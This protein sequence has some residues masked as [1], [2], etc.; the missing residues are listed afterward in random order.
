MNK[1]RIDSVVAI[2][3]AGDGGGKHR[4][5]ML[6]GVRGGY[7]LLWHRSANA[8][9][10]GNMAFVK[11]VMASAKTTDAEVG[12]TVVLESGG[13]IFY[14]I[15]IP[16]VEDGQ[17]EAIVEMQ[18]ETMLPV[19]RDEIQ[20]ASRTDRSSGGRRKVTAAI[21]RNEK[22]K[23]VVPIAKR[24]QASMVI[25]DCEGVVRAWKELFGG[26]DGK[27]VLVNIGEASSQ[28]ILADGGRLTCA[29]AIDLG[30]AD[31]LDSE[32]FSA[33]AE[34]FGRDLAEAIEL[35][36][37]SNRS[38]VE[39]FVLSDKAERYE[40]LILSLAELGVV[41]KAAIA[42][43]K[44]LGRQCELGAAEVHE[45]CDVIGAGMLGLQPNGDELNLL[46]KLYRPVG[47]ESESAGQ[48]SLRRPCII[49]AVM[50]VLFLFVC[51]AID[52]AMLSN[53]KGNLYSSEIEINAGAIIEKEN[54]R[55]LI[56]SERPDV[57][58]LMTKVNSSGPEGLM[59]DSFKFQKKQ[60][61]TISGRGKSYDQL[62]EFQKNLMAKSGISEVKILS[63][64]LDEK[65]NEVSF[66][67]TFHYKNFTKKK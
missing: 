15:E 39:I 37:M 9:E 56:A 30:S 61:V 2:S 54:V 19:A 60:P 5:V 41:A 4:A 51:Y 34:L 57:L 36:G 18:I 25:L 46:G 53:L 65:K 59:L 64:N 3:A 67:I 66:K 13:V 12:A 28:V 49:T 43:P 52:K 6:K 40:R 27:T 21:A 48:I 22:L 33:T 47:T 45:Y 7:E 1:D 55:K 26:G 17:V 62:Y 20:L 16:D 31:L 14:Q 8:E 29:T 32:K 24:S 50:I 23:A 58:D 11:E 44:L 63:P 38:D 42:D 35:F 10:M